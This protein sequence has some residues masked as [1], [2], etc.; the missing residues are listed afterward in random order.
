MLQRME[1][2]ISFLDPGDMDDGVDA[3]RALGFA[4]EVLGQIDDR[5][6]AT[7]IKARIDT[8]L[9]EADSSLGC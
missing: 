2:E 5:N 8:D 1:A 9:G 7:W 6:R 4:V 3:L